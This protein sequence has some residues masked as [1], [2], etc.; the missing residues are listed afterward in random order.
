MPA[1]PFVVLLKEF[2]FI[3]GFLRLCA[4][5]VTVL[6]RSGDWE[7]KATGCRNGGVTCGIVRWVGLM[8]G[9][10]ELGQTASS[11]LIQFRTSCTVSSG[12]SKGNR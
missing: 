8:S 5:T 2:I 12:C 10:I 11:L 1:M 3:S 6:E 9:T 4:M 7:R